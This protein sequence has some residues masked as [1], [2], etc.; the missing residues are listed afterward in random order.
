MG[1]ISNKIEYLAQTK[2]LLRE[3]IEKAGG[4][5]ADD[6]P[7]GEYPSIAGAILGDTISPVSTTL[8]SW[9]GKFDYLE[10]TKEQF[11]TLL[12]SHGETVTDTTPFRQ[13]VAK[14]E[15]VLPNASVIVGEDL[16]G[17]TLFIDLPIIE[18]EGSIGVPNTFVDLLDEWSPLIFGGGPPSDSEKAYL[19]GT[20]GTIMVR[21]NHAGGPDIWIKNIVGEEV[22]A[23]LKSAPGASDTINQ[24]CDGDL[25]GI[26]QS[27]DTTCPLYDLTKVI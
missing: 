12:T 18:A 19:E 20:E 25:I 23:I 7:F 10:K 24:E 9:D 27:V 11:R 26:V 3:T 5:I 21:N 4:S 15:N 2:S 22:F 13:Y 16:T 14:L 17:K 1:T 6:T 8:T